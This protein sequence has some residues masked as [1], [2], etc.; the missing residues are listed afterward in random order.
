MTHI[1]RK[2]EAFHNDS[3]FLTLKSNTMKNT[4]QSYEIF[5]QI[6]RFVMKIGYK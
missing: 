2:R 5:W 1:K 6:A 4:M 3:L